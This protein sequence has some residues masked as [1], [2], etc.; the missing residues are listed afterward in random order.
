LDTVLVRRALVNSRIKLADT[1]TLAENRGELVQQR[2][3]IERSHIAEGVR[4]A[5]LFK[6]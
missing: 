5:N 1:H 6:S 2:V 3:C 4:L